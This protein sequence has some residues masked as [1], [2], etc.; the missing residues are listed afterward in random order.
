[1]LVST[2]A[3]TS[4][5]SLATVIPFSS[6]TSSPGAERPKE[7]TPCTLSANLY[8][9]RVTPASHATVFDFMAAGSTDSMYSADW[10][11]KSSMQGIETTRTPAPSS[12]A[13]STAIESS[14]PAPIMIAS[15]SA[16]SLTI[17]YAPILVPAR[18]SA[19]GILASTGRFWRERMSAVGPV[20][21][22]IEWTYAAAVSSASPGRITSRLGM[23]RRDETVSTGWWVGPS[24]PTPIESC[25]Q[26]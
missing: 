11:S 13:A 5:T 21:R 22:S 23:R 24:S 8:H 14:E 15:S 3:L 10:R 1:M 17:V 9:G 20:L 19:A 26:M 16:V 18:L 4:S 6:Y 25:V 7:S 2:Y 12:A